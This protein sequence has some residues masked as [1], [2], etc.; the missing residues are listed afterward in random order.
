VNKRYTAWG[1]FSGPNWGILFDFEAF[2][3]KLMIFINP[4]QRGHSSGSTSHIF[5][6]KACHWQFGTL[7]GL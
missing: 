5:W 2:S 3:I 7:G 4:P 6:I 1:I